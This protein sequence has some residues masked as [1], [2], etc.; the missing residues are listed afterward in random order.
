MKVEHV[1]ESVIRFDIYLYDSHQ[2]G[3]AADYQL[4][5]L[6]YE[7]FACIHNERLRCTYYQK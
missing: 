1:E 5:K 3:A 6:K 7:D 2:R 4:A